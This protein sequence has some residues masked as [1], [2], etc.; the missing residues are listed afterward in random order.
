MFLLTAQNS[1]SNRFYSTNLH[2]PIHTHIRTAAKPPAHSNTLTHSIGAI[3]GFSILAKGTS[4]CE[5]PRPGI[6][7]PT[8]L[9]VYD[10][11]TT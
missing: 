11:F 2:L 1:N 10:C 8:F 6:E 3:F 4:A 5:L 7:Q 9:K